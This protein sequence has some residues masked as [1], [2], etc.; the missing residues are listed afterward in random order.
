MKPDVTHIDRAISKNL[1]VLLSTISG[2]RNA[3]SEAIHSARVATRRLRAVLPLAWA[4]SPKTSWRESAEI[5]REFGRDLGRV[6]EV[7]VVLEQLS[8]VEARIP[9][10]APALALVRQELARQQMR[11]HRRLVKDVE[12][13]PLDQLHP[14]SLVPASRFTVLADRRWRSVERAIADHADRLREAIDHAS[15]VYFPKRAHRARVET[16]KLRYLLE[17]MAHAAAAKSAVKRLKRMQDV[18]GD[19]HDQQMLVETL[20]SQD[21]IRQSERDAMTASL[22][23]RCQELF[24]QYLSRR[25]AVLELC[26]EVRT[27]ALGGEW[28]PASVGGVLLRASAAAVPPVLLWLTRPPSRPN[29]PAIVKQREPEPI[30]YASR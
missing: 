1:A 10:A 30:Q 17:L 26:D 21:A 16:K 7:E 14:K 3:E 22:D 18:L 4:E 15:G 5:I 25:S 19:L 28:R 2:I 6:R 8:G 27:A 29:R 11:Q 12:K 20:G 13:L 24:T 23:A 9:T